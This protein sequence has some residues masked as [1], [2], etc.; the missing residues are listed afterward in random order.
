MLRGEGPGERTVL[1]E[2]K[3]SFLYRLGTRCLESLLTDNENSYVRKEYK[4]TIYVEVFV[5]L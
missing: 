4:P 3:L 5:K 2:L 1:V